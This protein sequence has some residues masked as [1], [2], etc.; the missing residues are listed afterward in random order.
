MTKRTIPM[1]VVVL[2]VLVVGV[3]SAA[4]SPGLPLE[5]ADKAQLDRLVNQPV[6]I[7]PWAYAWRADRAVQE[8]PEAYFIP[9]RLERMDKVYRTA[10]Y[11]M[12][13]QELKSIYYEMPELIT[14]LLPKP[15]GKLL[16]GLLWTV[17]LADYRVELCWPAGVPEVPQPEAVEVRVYPTAF[18]WFGWCKDEILG[19]PQVSADR[20]TWKYNHS[21]ATEIPAAVGRTHRGGSATEMVAVFSEDGKTPNGGKSAV[22]S[23]R[24]IS[25]SVGPWKRMDVEMEWSFQAGTEKTDLDGCLESYVGVIGPVAPLA[26]DKGTTVTGAHA[27]QSRAAGDAR[28]GIVI[29]VLYVPGDRP[30]LDFATAVASLLADTSTVPYV[31]SSRP[32][33]DSRV[34]VWT[35][36]G[37]FTFRPCDLDKG[38]ILIPEHGVFVTKV[39]SG[40]TARQFVAELAAKNLKS[41]RRMTREH[42]EAASWH[43]VMREVR[44]WTCPAGT[45]VP[46]FPH[47]EDPP[48]QVQLPDARWTDAWRTASFQLKGKHMW[49][50]LAYEV[51]RVAHEM[52]L[53]GLHEEADKVYQYFLK[54]PGAKPDGDY[55]DG[56][57]ALEWATSMRHDMGYSHDGTH[58]S[59]GRLLFGM[60]DRYFLTGDKVW[61][62]RNR[63]RM[64]AAADWIIRQRKLYMKEIPNR[65]DLLV[66]GLMPPCMLGDYALPSCDWRWYYPD[67]ALSLQGLQRFADAVAEFDAGAGRKYRDEADAFRGNLRRAVDREA[68]L[69]PVRLG[70]DGTY[71]SFIPNAAYTRG[72]MLAL[73]FGSLQR[74]QGDTVV[75]ALPLAEPF[76]ALDAND[77]RMVGTLD[78]MEEVGT[79]V[80]VVRELEEARKKKGLS[81]DDAWFWNFYAGFP[82]CSHNA[83]IYLLQDDVPSFL[84][85]WMN[86]Y[87]ALVG[88]NG[89]MWEWHRLAA[90][91]YGD[92]T[93]SDN[94]TAGWFMENFRNLLVMEDGRSLWVARATPRVWLEQGKKVA[95]KSA[96]TY[97]GT[98]AYEIVSDVDHGKITAT[99]EIPS[100]RPPKSAIVR[101]RHPK[102]QP[103]KSVTVNGQPWSGFNKDKEVVELTGW[104]G[105]VVAVATY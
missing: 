66:A 9:R 19:K 37:G 13:A 10:F 103:I 23:I 46:P 1:G 50:G 2:A 5:A 90:A 89:K 69:S 28:R 16:A 70:R 15:K 36:A 97:F 86:S 64:Q 11:E 44:L 80:G 81:T 78:V 75:G 91:E 65:Q 26:D 73:E 82:K 77:V 67:N 74:P 31:P 42:R 29:P 3:A 12:P 87:A 68:A 83:N 61:F 98:L 33:L 71:R 41:V 40:K 22:P 17:R 101:L 85:F 104:T 47:V 43:E 56:N 14:P 51:A 39:G 94:G 72:T 55:A 88:A 92:C 38:P 8:K 48:M 30:S 99:V 59:T 57:G 84:R 54:A 32:T 60:A 105:K 63:V 25:P 18:G 53:V 95:V 6:D 7:A 21:C 34:T 27:W 100:R 62:Q 35:K 52:D 96:P 79:S 20:R 76:A 58:A 4:Q 49:G 93:S 102:A 45:A 24:V